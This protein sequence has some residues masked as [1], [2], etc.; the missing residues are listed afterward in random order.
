MTE[1]QK[2]HPRGGIIKVMTPRGRIL[3]RFWLNDG[4]NRGDEWPEQK[5][6]FAATDA[7]GNKLTVQL[8][9]VFDLEDP[10]RLRLKRG[11]GKRGLP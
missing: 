4:F 1:R 10:G 9:L 5:W 2:L 3:H 11:A 7:E 8:G 6:D